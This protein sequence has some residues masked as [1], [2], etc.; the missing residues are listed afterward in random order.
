MT[1][2]NRPPVLFTIGAKSIAEG[3][4]VSFTV[5][6]KDDDGQTVKYTATGLPSGAA[7]T[8]SS[9]GTFTWT[10]TSTQAGTYKVTFK[11]SDGVATDS[12]IV[13]ITVSNS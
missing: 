11:A 13:T 6:G 12:E 4:K 10:P 7:F 3:S 9:Y 1:N 2:V 5:K 8:C